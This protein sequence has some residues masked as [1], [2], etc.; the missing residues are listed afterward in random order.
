M[1]TN[2]SRV[3]GKRSLRAI[4]AI[5]IALCVIVT[6]FA[7]PAF[8]D[9]TTRYDVTIADG[10][11]ENVVTTTETEP[12]KILK[13]AGISVNSG[14]KLNLTEFVSGEGG[15]ISISRINNINV[16]YNESI[17]TYGVYSATV[18]EAL[19]EIGAKVGE[20]DKV[21]YKLSDSVIDG[22]VIQIKTAFSVSVEA[23]GKKNQFAFADGTVKDVLN[24]AKIKLGKNDYT[25]PSLNTELEAGMNIKV[26]RVK[27]KSSVKKSEIAFETKKVADKTLYKGTEKV[28]TEGV[29]GEK[30]LTYKAK[31][32]NGKLES[33]EKVGEKVTKKPVTKVI[34]YGTKIKPPGA[35]A[36]PNGVKSKNGYKV[37][38]TIS[39]RYTHYCAC[40][41]CN[42]NGRGITSSGRKITNGMKNPYY[43]AC[44]WLPLGSVINVDG[45][46]YTVVDRGGRGLSKKGRIDI[47][48]PEGHAACYRKGTGSCT[49]KIVRLGW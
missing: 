48:T 1:M 7:A 6:V 29:N 20:N 5:V 26:Y 39:G 10:S 27:F 25:K 3:A 19:D 34:R 38:Q 49:I 41:R 28:A 35:D 17:Q 24:K 40:A 36:T 31:Y 44:N 45:T 15:K 12:I 47:F 4:L 8:A 11:K 2:E 37:G 46:N 9:S 22:M 18:G 43:I 33:R 42:G 32:V 13:D 21:N 14:D 16:D 23:D 30:A